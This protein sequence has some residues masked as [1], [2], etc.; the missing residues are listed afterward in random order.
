MAGKYY[1]DEPLFTENE[2]IEHGI[3]SIHTTNEPTFTPRLA[4]TLFDGRRI[5]FSI[6]VG[7]VHDLRMM[8]IDAMPH[9]KNVIINE[10][11][12]Y[13]VPQKREIKRVYSELD[14]YGEERWED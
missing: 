5:S 14:P 12:H 1:N 8:G 6:S 7:M 2:M 3:Q 13:G 9:L 10:I 11:E 4:V